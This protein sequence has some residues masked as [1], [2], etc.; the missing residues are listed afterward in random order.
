MYIIWYNSICKEVILI[1]Q[2]SGEPTK[3]KNNYDIRN[4]KKEFKK[5][6]WL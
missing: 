2:Q 3:E 5:E 1:T 4:I 6:I